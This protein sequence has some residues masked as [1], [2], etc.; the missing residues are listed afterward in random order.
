MEL[1]IIQQKIYEIR[2]AKVMLDFDLAT[3]YQVETRALKQAVRRNADRFPID[4]AFQLTKEEWQELITNCDKFPKNIHHTPVPPTAFTEEGVAM[5][6]SV[7]HSKMAVHVNISIMRAFVAMRNYILSQASDSVELAQLR[8]RVLRLEQAASDI[9]EDVK[10]CLSLHAK[11][12]MLSTKLSGPCRSS[13][14]RSSARRGRS[15]S[16]DMKNSYNIDIQ[17]N[18]TNC[19]LRN[20]R[21]EIRWLQIVAI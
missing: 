20:E 12:L 2:G 15:G 13:C 4:F 17:I 7:L 18:V 21:R 6:A 11:I 14:Q 1:Q 3:L 8:E 10:I 16:G 19:D 9:L 5:L